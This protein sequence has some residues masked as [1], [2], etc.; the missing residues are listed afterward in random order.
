MDCDKLYVKLWQTSES[1]HS[2]GSSKSQLAQ[3]RKLLKTTHPEMQ[4]PKKLLF[5]DYII[6]GSEK[7][8]HFHHKSAG[9]VR[10]PEIIPA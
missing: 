10:S 9:S 4:A 7:N 5:K 8:V 1:S 2:H 3:R 6:C